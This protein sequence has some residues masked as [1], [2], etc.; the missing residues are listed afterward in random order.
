MNCVSVHERRI[1]ACL[2]CQ[3]GVQDYETFNNQLESLG[4][5]LVEAED[6]LRA[7]D[8]NGCTDLTVIQDRME[9]LKVSDSFLF[10]GRL[11]KTACEQNMKNPY[12]S[13]CFF[14]EAHAEI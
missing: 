3:T 12:L 6:A 9:E 13:S 7:Q 14:A 11:D 10:T 5:S 4:C 1:F 2:L 8:P